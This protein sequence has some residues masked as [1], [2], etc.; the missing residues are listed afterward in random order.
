MVLPPLKPV[1]IDCPRGALIPGRE[2]ALSHPTS[3][4]FNHR[5]SGYGSKH[6]GKPATELVRWGRK[7]EESGMRSG[8]SDLS[9]VLA[10]K[11]FFF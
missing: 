10:S 1:M 3:H 8:N 7:L 4:Y 11:N 6:A 9:Q 2:G 5:V